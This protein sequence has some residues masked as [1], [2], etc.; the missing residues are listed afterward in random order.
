M[1]YYCRTISRS[2]RWRASPIVRSACCA[3]GWARATRCRKWSRPNPQLWGTDKSRRRTDHAGEV[4]PIAV[5]IA[6]ADPRDARGRGAL[7]RRSRRADHRHQHG[8]PGEEGVQRGGGLGA[9]CQRAAGRARSSRP[10]CGAVDVP[11]TLKIRTGPTRASAMR[12]AHRAHRRGRRHRGAR[13]ARAHARMPV[14]GRRRVR[15]GRARSSARCAFRCSPTATSRRRRRARDVLAHTGADGLMIGRAAQ[16]RPWIFREIAHYLATGTMLAA[17]DGRRGARRDPRAPRRSL[18]VLRRGAGRAHRAQAPALV[19]GG[20]CR[21]AT[22][23]RHAINAVGIGGGADRGRRAFLRA[24][25]RR[26][27]AVRYSRRGDLTAKRGARHARAH[28]AGGG[29][30]RGVKKASATEQQQRN[31]PQ[32]RAFAGR[33]LPPARRRAAAW[34]LR[35]GDRARRARAARRRCSTG[36]TATRR[37][38]RKCWA[39]PQ[40]AARE[41]RQVQAHLTRW[42]VAPCTAAHGTA[43]SAIVAQALLSVSDKSGIV[44]FARGLARSASRCFPPAARRRRSADAGIAGDRHRHATPDSPKCWTGA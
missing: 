15:H 27:R 43:A 32:R 9:A 6:G 3:S 39:E 13:G 11:V 38:R 7:Q 10:S 24:A 23:F 33:I 37:R 25:R 16:G 21:A 5:Q 40:Y 14:R 18:R 41:A 8:L 44:E 29:G 2:R 42:P 28:A 12:V 1:A 4:A 30:T 35:H 19:H 26:R 36:R 31:R 34:H 20:A 17:A 22:T